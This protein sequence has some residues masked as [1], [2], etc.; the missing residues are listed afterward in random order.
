VDEIATRMVPWE[1]SEFSHSRNRPHHERPAL[2]KPGEQVWYRRHDWNHDLLSGE[3][4]E[5]EL[6]VVVEVQPPDDETLVCELPDVGRVRDLN[7]W[8]LVRDINGRPIYDAG[9][10]RYVHVADPWPWIRMRRPNGMIAETREARLRGS[11][12]W[13]PL[14]YLS[15]PE[16]WRLPSGTLLVPRPQLRPLAAPSPAP[17]PASG[18]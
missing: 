8:H 3:T 4:E 12:G 2:P 11:A 9:M 1:Q 18:W 10:P 6:V 15:R 14:D 5:P 13:L 17:A 16:R 7:L